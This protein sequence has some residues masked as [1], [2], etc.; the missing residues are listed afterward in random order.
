MTET[1]GLITVLTAIVKRI[2]AEEAQEST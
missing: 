1:D 2:I